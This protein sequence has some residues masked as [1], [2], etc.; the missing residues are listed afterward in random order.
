MIKKEKL[1]LCFSS[2]FYKMY[3]QYAREFDSKTNMV[4]NKC[5]Q[6][7]PKGTDL[8]FVIDDSGSISSSEWRMMINFMKDFIDSQKIG[9]DADQMRVS[10]TFF[11]SHSKTVNYDYAVLLRN[12]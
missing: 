10:L 4:G 1:N 3:V 6:C 8:V 5:M 12:G 9:P 11:S 7:K 2:H